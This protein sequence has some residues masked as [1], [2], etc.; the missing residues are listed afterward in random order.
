MVPFSIMEM[1]V[2]AA[3]AIVATQYVAPVLPLPST[4]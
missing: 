4:A 3:L 1:A 2:I